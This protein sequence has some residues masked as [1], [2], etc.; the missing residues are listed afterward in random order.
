MALI[1]LDQISLAFGDNPLLDHVDWVVQPN[2]RIALIGR[3]GAGKS[4]LL[5]L[6]DHQH[7]ADSGELWFKAGLKVAMLAQELPPADNSTVTEFVTS[8]VAEVQQWLA[9]YERLALQPD[10]ASMQKMD[11]LQHQIEAVDGWSLPQRVEQVLS[12]LQLPGQKKMSDLSG[13]W[14]RRV[15]LAKA[16]VVEPDILLLDEP[17]NHLDIITIQWLEKQLLDFNGTIVFITHDR[18]FLQNLANIIVELDRGKLSSWE[19]D[20]QG[21]LKYREQVLA[22]EERHNALFDKKLAQEEVWIR[23]GIKARRTRNEGRVRALKSLR[24]ERAQRR[25]RQGKANFNLE[26]GSQSGKRVSHLESVNFAH[27][28]EILIKDLTFTLLRG[29]KVGLIGPN[30]VGKST[31]L[32]VLLGQLKPGSGKLEVGTNLEIAYFDQFREQ[33]DPEKTVIDSVAEGREQITINGRQRHLIGYLGDFLFPPARTRVKV[34]S[35]SGGERNRLMLAILFS[36]PANLLVMDEPTNDLDLETLELLEE[37]LTE[38]DGTLL[39][40]SHDRAFLDNVVTSTLAFE[41]NGIIREY[42]GGYDDWIRQGGHFQSS[43]VP[44]SNNSQVEN[45]TVVEKETVAD[46]KPEKLNYKKLSYKLQRE[47]KTLP[48][49]IAG[50]EEKIEMLQLETSEDGFYQQDH[51]VVNERLSALQQLESTLEEK[52]ERWMELEELQQGN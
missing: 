42:V 43:V 35:L 46:K 17:T 21:F 27:G 4:T 31:F 11:K 6:I 45:K 8:G 12:R 38:F 5:K 37:I 16:L 22:D 23:Q 40:V 33:L 47:L 1:R 20:Y 18:S 51:Q 36:K 48:S 44:E 9:E 14:R 30:G 15:A 49:D 28:S 25:E 10:A 41:G 24:E 32:K 34:K 52:M 13:G 39:L 26:G 7:K 2:Q 29:D 19:G 50:L 3:N